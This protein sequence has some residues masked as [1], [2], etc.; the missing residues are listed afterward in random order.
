MIRL[1]YNCHNLN[2][3]ACYFIE[4]IFFLFNLLR[5]NLIG[6]INITNTRPIILTVEVVI[7]FNL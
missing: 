6:F 1:N 4:N 3:W 7:K 2:L 5:T